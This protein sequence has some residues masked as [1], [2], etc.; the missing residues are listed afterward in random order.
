[1]NSPLAGSAYHVG[2]VV[3]LLQSGIHHI[4]NQQIIS[5]HHTVQRSVVHGDAGEYKFIP[6]TKLQLC[7]GLT[8]HSRI[9]SFSALVRAPF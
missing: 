8:R 6:L 2:R 3:M 7:S 4:M 9:G 5:V 1:M